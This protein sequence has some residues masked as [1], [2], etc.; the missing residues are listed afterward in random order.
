MANE[1]DQV[2]A[3]INNYG[4]AVD[5]ELGY[6]NTARARVKGTKDQPVFVKNSNQPGSVK[7]NEFVIFVAVAE[8]DAELAVAQGMSATIKTIIHKQTQVV[9]TYSSA[10]SAWEQKGSLTALEAEYPKACFYFSDWNVKC[11][12]FSQANVFRRTA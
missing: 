3:A 12:Y 2:V 10:T 9:W 6:T 1:A 7:S 8:D 11:F 4:T 5:R